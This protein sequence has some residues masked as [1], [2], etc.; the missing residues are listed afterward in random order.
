MPAGSSFVASSLRDAA[1]P[2]PQPSRLPPCCQRLQTDIARH[3]RESGKSLPEKEN[4]PPP[5]RLPLG[6]GLTFPD[7][8]NRGHLLGEASSDAMPPRPAATARSLETAALLLGIPPASACDLYTLIIQVKD[9]NGAEGCLS[10]STTA[11]IKI[12]DVNDNFPILEKDNYEGTVEE[13][14]ANVEVMRIKVLDADLIGSDNWLADFQIESGKQGEYFMI[15]MN[16]SSNEGRL[17]LKREVDFEEMQLLE[18][19]LNVRNK[20][21]F[22]ESVSY[23]Y[24]SKSIPF[25]DILL[26]PSAELRNGS[27]NI[28]STQLLTHSITEKTESLRSS[29]RMLNPFG[30]LNGGATIEGRGLGLSINKTGGSVNHEIARCSKDI[31]GNRRKFGCELV[32]S[33]D[34]FNDIA[35]PDGFLQMYYFQKEEFYSE[36]CPLQVDSLL[37]FSNE[38][39]VSV[40]SSI[41][42]C[43]GMDERLHDSFFIDLDS[44]FKILAE[45]CTVEESYDA[46][47]KRSMVRS[48][49]SSVEQTP[50]APS[51][52]LF[53]NQTWSSVKEERQ[54]PSQTIYENGSVTEYHRTISS[55]DSPSH[56]EKNLIVSG[57]PL[58][59]PQ[60]MPYTNVPIIK[61]TRYV[62]PQIPLKMCISDWSPTIVPGDHGALRLGEIPHPQNVFH[63]ERRVNLSPP[64]QGGVIG[65]DSDH[66]CVNEIP[67]VQNVVLQDQSGVHMQG[68]LNGLKQGIL[69]KH[70]ILA[71][72]IQKG[73]E[74]RTLNVS[75]TQ[76]FQNV[77]KVEKRKQTMSHCAENKEKK[78]SNQK[79]C[80]EYSSKR[81]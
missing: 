38:D 77:S 58:C 27:N 10:S 3:R 2:S 59:I 79:L 34:E 35:L 55:T 72:N 29:G 53:L 78:I 49:E 54:T 26:L 11:Q 9:L 42:L 28:S 39:N 13:N 61:V 6:R 45:I 37:E 65:I 21:E 66:L 8:P 31:F 46:S 71:T 76:H 52:T 20:A 40:V 18:L 56:T 24:K 4:T 25:I 47:H 1:S 7:P 22:H 80:K 33:E 43:S 69:C 62:E 60:V 73:L 23:Q 41:E 44:K 12:L 74:Q 19:A 51:S 15:E 5:G 30:A 50:L 57:A 81:H 14:A 32:E 64:I 17:I 16:E 67:I 70:E 68:S 48:E 75:E 63:T 36:E